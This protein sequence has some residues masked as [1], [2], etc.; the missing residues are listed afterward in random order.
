MLNCAEG[1]FESN[2]IHYPILL[3]I[4]DVAR[5]SYCIHLELHL[6]IVHVSSVLAWI[7]GQLDFEDVAHIEYTCIPVKEE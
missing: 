3:V 2:V 5:L 6:S 7:K 4:V 1:Y